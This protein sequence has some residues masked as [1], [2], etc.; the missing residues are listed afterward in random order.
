MKKVTHLYSQP[1][2][3]LLQTGLS[4]CSDILLPFSRVCSRVCPRQ[5]KPLVGTELE[6]AGEKQRK[7]RNF[8]GRGKE[9]KK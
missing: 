3:P 1:T 8:L 9:C 4:Q 2:L 6:E 5:V 7:V